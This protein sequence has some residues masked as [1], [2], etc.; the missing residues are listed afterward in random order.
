MKHGRILVNLNIM[1]K[2][3]PLKTNLDISG[4]AMLAQHLEMMAPGL[5]EG[6]LLYL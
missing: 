4:T 5:V 3:T 2:L 6:D 1:I